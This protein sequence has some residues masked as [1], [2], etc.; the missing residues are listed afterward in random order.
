[1]KIILLTILIFS[2]NSFSLDTVRY[3]CKK[4]IHKLVKRGCKVV[5][6]RGKRAKIFEEKHQSNMKCNKSKK[7]TILT[8]RKCAFGRAISEVN[9][10]SFLNDREYSGFR[11]RTH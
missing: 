9:V 11:S 8:D 6:L 2:F 7:V 5:M 10:K 3:V 4:N 1:M